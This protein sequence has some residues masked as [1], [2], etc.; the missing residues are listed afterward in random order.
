MYNTTLQI[1]ILLALQDYIFTRHDPK[2]LGDLIQS[3]ILSDQIDKIL[4]DIK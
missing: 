4:K 2:T 1:I 3:Q